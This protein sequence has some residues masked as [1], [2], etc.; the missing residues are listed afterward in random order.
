[1]PPDQIGKW[2]MEAGDNTWDL[3]LCDQAVRVVQRTLHAPGPLYLNVH[4]D[5]RASVAAAEQLLASR[6]GRLVHLEH[7]GGR[8]ITFRLG[9]KKFSIDP[10][11][12]FSEPGIQASLRPKQPSRRR[13]EA[14]RNVAAFADELVT[15]LHLKNE[16]I[17]VALHN[18]TN[19]GDLGI[20]RLAAKKRKNGLEAVNIA[21]GQDRDDFYWVTEKHVY[22][23]LVGGGWNVALQASDAPDDGS[24]SLWCALNGVR[25]INVETQDGK[26]ARQ[27]RMLEAIQPLL[28]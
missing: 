22:D 14:K 3:A 24:L 10:N 23:E 26:V 27:L 18:N 6:P 17:V 13:D 21:R 5:E 2:R 12:I 8:R 4:E 15:Q 11:R 28:D 20:E 9:Q 19:R 7:D 1:M 16:R 25:Y